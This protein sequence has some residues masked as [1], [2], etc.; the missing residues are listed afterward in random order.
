MTARSKKKTIEE[1]RED[2]KRVWGDRYTVSP[3]SKYTGTH[4]KITITCPIHG[5]FDVVANSFLHGHGCKKCADEAKIGKN[6][7]SN[8]VVLDRLKDKLGDKYLLDKVEYLNARTKIM[9]G[10]REHG[11]FPIRYSDALQYHG[12]PYCQSSRLELGLK[13]ELEKN[14][15]NFKTQYSFEWM[16][17]SPCSK[18]TYDFY[19]QDINIAIECQGRQHFEPVKAFGGE[20]EFEK[21]KLRDEMKKSMSIEHGVRLIYFLDKKYNKYMKPDDTYFNTIDDLLLFLKHEYYEKQGRC[22]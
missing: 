22:T 13:N 6:G 7:L 8:E 18:L 12:C 17:T 9:L 15:I 2:V 16:R 21:V 19:V 10:C 14:N 5:E 1:F 20:I 11:Y 3:H 4:S